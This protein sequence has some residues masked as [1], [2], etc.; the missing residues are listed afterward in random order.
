MAQR[1]GINTVARYHE[2]YCN[3]LI[4]I[5]NYILLVNCVVYYTAGLRC[6]DGDASLHFLASKCL[7]TQIG[8][9]HKSISCF[10]QKISKID[11]WKS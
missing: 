7:L 2:L 1:L 9:H 11:Q 4:I 3:I 6:L 5:L 8:M 10:M